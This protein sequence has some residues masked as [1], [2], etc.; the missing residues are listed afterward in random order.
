MGRDDNQIV[1]RKAPWRLIVSGAVGLGLFGALAGYGLETSAA[2]DRHTARNIREHTATSTDKIARECTILPP[3]S[4]MNCV[5]DVRRASQNF[6]SAE[7]EVLAQR[8]SAL[9]SFIMAIA[10]ML[11]LLLSTLG[12]FFV[13]TTF[14]ETKRANHLVVLG[15]RPWLDFDVEISQLDISVAGISVEGHIRLTNLGETP[16]VQVYETIQCSFR[17]DRP[18]EDDPFFDCRDDGMAIL[19]TLIP[20][21]GTKDLNI[22]RFATFKHDLDKQDERKFYGISLIINVFYKSTAFPDLLQTSK[23]VTIGQEVGQRVPGAF[24][25]SFTEL[26]QCGPFTLHDAAIH[27]QESAGSYRVI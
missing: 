3:A 23:A 25:F 16:A 7:L 2:Y 10:A 4:R 8:Q 26:L 13:W 24:E 9:W 17:E 6:T 11:G 5:V 1:R 19:P 12:V 22:R 27:V 20:P 18:R 21:N 15:R 14:A